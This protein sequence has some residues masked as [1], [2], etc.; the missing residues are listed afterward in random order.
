MKSQRTHYRLACTLLSALA[1]CSLTIQA[2]GFAP[3]YSVDAQSASVP[4]LNLPGNILTPVGTGQVP[5][6]AVVVQDFLLG[7]G[8]NSAGLAGELDA[9]SYGTDAKL[10]KGTAFQHYWTFSVDEFAVGRPGVPGPSVSTEG[11]FGAQEA[12]GDIYASTLNPGPMLPFPGVNSGLFDGNGGLTP[13][14]APGLNLR[15]PTNPTV[16]NIDSGDNLDAWDLDQQIPVAVAGTVFNT[17]IYFSL[18]SQFGDPLEMPLA[19]NTGTAVANGFVG[20]DVLVSLFAGGAPLL[21]APAFMLGLDQTGPDHDDLDALVL[22]ENGNGVYNG[23]TGPYSWANGNTDMLL[24]SVRRGSA[25]IG[26]PD[27]LLGLP[28]EEGDILMPPSAP[29]GLPGIFVPAEAL[30]LVTVRT[31]GIAATFQ[32]YGDD[33]DGLDVQQ[34]TIPEPSTCLLLLAGVCGL[35]TRRR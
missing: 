26:Q 7:I 30:G 17:P 5:P 24:F 25:V 23:P 34:R 19:F 31:F 6:P 20:G 10:D 15:E 32:G 21:Y 18:D 2:H 22:W 29:G 33:L 14:P 4:G 11:A 12:A 13:F 9:L 28:I 35:A 8:P 27:S 1:V 16:G 3:T